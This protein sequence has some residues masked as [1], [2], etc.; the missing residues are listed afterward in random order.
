LEDLT[1]RLRD[2]DAEPCVGIQLVDSHELR[3]DGNVEVIVGCLGTQRR[4]RLDQDIN[5]AITVGVGPG[6][7]A[8]QGLVAAAS[9]REGLCSS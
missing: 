2:P 7:A 3:V 9:V 6:P 1:P 4:V 8:G 5:G